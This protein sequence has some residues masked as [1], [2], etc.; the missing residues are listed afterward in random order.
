[1]AVCDAIGEAVYVGRNSFK[2][3]QKPQTNV[4]VYPILG[5]PF[6]RI[7]A[8]VE[9]GIQLKESRIPNPSSTDKK[10]GNQY[11]YLK[12]GIHRAESRIQ[13]CLGLFCMGLFILV[14]ANMPCLFDS[15]MVQKKAKEMSATRRHVDQ[16]PMVFQ[17]VWK[18]VYYYSSISSLKLK[19]TR[20]DSSIKG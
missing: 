2:R 19:T 4:S 13:D 17:I 12:F 3:S 5:N 11:M 14:I 15:I 6:S 9:S 18:P 10:S 8:I 7:R 16:S 1:M 20:N